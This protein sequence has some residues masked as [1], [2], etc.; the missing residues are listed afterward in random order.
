MTSRFTSKQIW[1][2]N[3]FAGHARM[4]QS[5]A[6]CIIGSATATKKSKELAFQIQNLAHE[7]GESLKER[8][9]QE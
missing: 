3:S 5:Q 1:V 4:M 8:A 7:L 2:H 6:S 9:E